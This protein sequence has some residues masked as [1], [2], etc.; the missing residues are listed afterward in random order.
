[1]FGLVTCKRSAYIWQT[2]LGECRAS[3]LSDNNNCMVEK[4]TNKLFSHVGSNGVQ[5]QMMPRDVAQSPAL[6]I[7]I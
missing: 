7:R 4:T 2:Y 5:L 6:N 1:M 3:Y